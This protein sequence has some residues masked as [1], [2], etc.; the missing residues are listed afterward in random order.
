MEKTMEQNISQ[1]PERDLAIKIIHM[2]DNLSLG[3]RRIAKELGKQGF[4]V[5]KDS[6]NR[7]YRKFKET[8]DKKQEENALTLIRKAENRARQRVETKKEKERI[9]IQLTVLFV[10]EHTMTFEQREKLFTDLETLL[11]FAKRIMPVVDPM[12]WTEFVEYCQESCDDLAYALAFAIGH[13]RDYERPAMY[14]GE[15]QRFDLYLQDRMRAW[16]AAGEKQELS[17]NTGDSETDEPESTME[18]SETEICTIE[19]PEDATY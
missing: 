2:H 1:L 4:K 13:Q 8:D 14:S 17:E 15:K 5:N 9:R 10:E 19:L 6:V 7:L 12:L 16:L 18:E 11:R 3:Y